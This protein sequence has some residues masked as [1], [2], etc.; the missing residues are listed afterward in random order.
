MQTPR[1][2]RGVYLPY[3]KR[4]PLS[5]SSR[6]TSAK[7]GLARR[8]LATVVYE[9]PSNLAWEAV[10]F[11]ISPMLPQML[12]PWLLAILIIL[13]LACLAIWF[14]GRFYGDASLTEPHC[15]K[16]GYDLRGFVGEPPVRCSEC[17]ADLT[18]G[19]AVRWGQRRPRKTGAA[20][21]WSSACLAILAAMLLTLH[22][23]RSIAPAPAIMWPHRA[24]VISPPISNISLL[25]KLES[26]YGSS[27][28]WDECDR[29]L[30][31]GKLSRGIC[32]KAIDGLIEDLPKERRYG[33]WPMSI[34]RFV[35][36]VDALQWISAKQYGR[37]VEAFYGK[38][39]VVMSPR[40][41][42][43]ALVPFELT[44]FG[45]WN[46]PGAAKVSA[47]QS[48]ETPD[49]PALPLVGHAYPWDTRQLDRGWLTAL[50]SQE[51]YGGFV[52]HLSPG[53]YVLRFKFTSAILPPRF[54]P[55]VHGGRPG[56]PDHWPTARYRWTT[57]VAVPV[58]VVPSY[59]SPIEVVTDPSMAIDAAQAMHVDALRVSRV[60]NGVMVSADITL[61]P[62]PDVGLSG[63]FVLRINGIEHTL[64]YI[65]AKSEMNCIDMQCLL[66]SLG[67]QVKFAEVILRPHP[68]YAETVPGLASVW[69]APLELFNQVLTRSDLHGR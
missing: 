56:G 67:P 30:S 23:K 7:P 66:P 43:G 48:V 39:R 35:K 38:P 22:A 62:R 55:E 37:L 54:L 50:S 68:A 42:S 25:H 24:T 5:N 47:L 19:H 59:V 61:K 34:Q 64:S 45:N 1:P 33:L 53:Q 27:W 21:V 14:Q 17:G 6:R 8:R 60:N 52:A 65:A 44:D 58:T 46:L 29:R 2:G 40:I 10:A 4:F 3:V 11:T 18:A 9:S 20:M 16:C 57:D 13:S 31:S 36:E 69:G 28:A 63:Y 26:M 51:A 41:R 32:V 12:W 49:G 15:A